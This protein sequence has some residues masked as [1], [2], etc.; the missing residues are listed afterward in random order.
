MAVVGHLRQQPKVELDW[1]LGVSADSRELPG[2]FR[3][4]RYLIVGHVVSFHVK[5][6]PFPECRHFG[7]NTGHETTFY[8]NRSNK[9]WLLNPITFPLFFFEKL[10]SAK[11][12]IPTTVQLPDDD[13]IATGPPLSP[14]QNCVWKKN[15]SL[16]SLIAYELRL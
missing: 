9:I 3:S 11:L 2:I 14:Y 10:P 13:C 8:S 7:F 16:I 6:N 12:L 1:L 5:V 15:M 4:S